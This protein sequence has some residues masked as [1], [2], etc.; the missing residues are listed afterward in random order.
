[1]HSRIHIIVGI[2]LEK[3]LLVVLEV[4][5]DKYNLS[6]NQKEC[7]NPGFA[8]AVMGKTALQSIVGARLILSTDHITNTSVELQYDTAW[9][10]S[11]ENKS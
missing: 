7:A 3:F 6:A 2:D 9:Y 1:M 8:H 5:S 11:G 4:R 10:T